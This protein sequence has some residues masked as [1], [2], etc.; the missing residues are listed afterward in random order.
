MKIRRQASL[1]L[2]HIMVL[3]DDRQDSVL[4]AA[5]GGVDRSQPLYS[6]NLILGGGCLLY[7]SESI[8]GIAHAVAFERRK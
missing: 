4:Q 3:I 8:P 1:E 5:R 2:P 6:A 7:T